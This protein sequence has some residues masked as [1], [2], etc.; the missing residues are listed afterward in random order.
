MASAVDHLSQRVSK[1]AP[2]RP[3]TAILVISALLVV[4]YFPVL[5]R[6]VEQWMQDADMGHGFFVPVIAGY[7]AWQKRDQVLAIEPKPNY[8]GLLLLAWGACQLIVGML[9]VELFL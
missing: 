7:I 6:L 5:K 9:G 4:C 3:W 8:W 2:P 1:P